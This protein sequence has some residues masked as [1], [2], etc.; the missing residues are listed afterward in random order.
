MLHGTTTSIKHRFPKLFRTIFKRELLSVISFSFEYFMHSNVWNFHSTKDRVLIIIYD[1][2]VTCSYRQ[3]SW[4]SLKWVYWNAT[5][6]KKRSIVW[7]KWWHHALEGEKCLRE[8]WNCGISSLHK[9]LFI[10]KFH[11]SALSFLRSHSYFSAFHSVRKSKYFHIQQFS[12]FPT[13]RS[14]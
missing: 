1:I 11:I 10:G 3:S 13:T 6:D 9:R 12:K 14:V 8:A 2:L 4:P 5:I 7:S